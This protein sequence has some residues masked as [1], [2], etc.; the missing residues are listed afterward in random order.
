MSLK[1]RLAR[2]EEDFWKPEG[3][4]F[5]AWAERASAEEWQTFWSSIF[6]SLIERG[7]AP[8]LPEDF[9]EDEEVSDAYVS[10]LADGLL[11]WTCA[12]KWLATGGQDGAR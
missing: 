4:A 5:R 7:L 10:G 1:H 2:L 3:E 11:Q 12:E 8:P 6:S 9:W